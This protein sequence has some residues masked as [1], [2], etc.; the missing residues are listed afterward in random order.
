MDFLTIQSSL[1]TPLPIGFVSIKKT[2]KVRVATKVNEK[3]L[4]DKSLEKD[5]MLEE[6][7][8]SDFLKANEHDLRIINTRES[9]S[10]VS[11][12]GSY[13]HGDHSKE[14]SEL[15]SSASSKHEI[16]R[17]KF[18]VRG[19]FRPVVGKELDIDSKIKQISR[20]IEENNKNHLKKIQS[21]GKIDRMAYLKE[22][23]CLDKFENAKKNW[24]SIE[25]GIKKK[26]R[27]RDSQL[28]SHRSKE[29]SIIEHE[30]PIPWNMTLRQGESG[31][32]EQLIP[33]GHKLSGIYLKEIINIE[34]LS[35]HHKSRSCPDLTIYGNSK[36]P[37]EVYAI[38]Q[39]GS[40][41]FHPRDNID[42][43][44]EEVFLENYTPG[45]KKLWTN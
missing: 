25:N 45:T 14:R 24:K 3:K 20:R 29:V 11:S 37:L 41:Y 28:L 27:K 22:A 12:I 17:R 39:P 26:L 16:H 2:R 13:K 10:R 1:N 18:T 9:H 43:L 5:F 23:T 6:G 38:K 8:P 42:R 21:L 40:R 32:V 35:G 44:Q 36:F 7:D 33:V 31:K 34:P 4:I 15:V 30:R 19:V